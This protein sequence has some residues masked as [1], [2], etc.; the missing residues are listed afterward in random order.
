MRA[1]IMLK[2][3]KAQYDTAMRAARSMRRQKSAT[4]YF[5]AFGVKKRRSVLVTT[6]TLIIIRFI[7]TPFLRAV[8][9]LS[10]FYSD[11]TRRY[12]RDAAQPRR[13]RVRGNISAKR[14]HRAAQT[15]SAARWRCWRVLRPGQQR[16]RNGRLMRA[17]TRCLSIGRA[18]A[19]TVHA[20][21]LSC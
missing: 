11:A 4:R 2:A 7:E 12:E 18:V 21:Q 15:A 3:H 9:R 6:P 13:A 17:P 19:Y 5:A 14:T 16:S 1:S 20:K 8:R 10:T